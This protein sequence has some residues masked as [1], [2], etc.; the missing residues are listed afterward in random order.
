MVQDCKLN[1]GQ[2]APDYFGKIFLHEFF[3]AALFLQITTRLLVAGHAWIWIL[4][5]LCV[6]V[7]YAVLIWKGIK[8]L[9]P[10]I[11]RARLLWN[12]ILM[13]FAFTSIRY[14]IP[15]LGKNPLDSHLAKIDY[16]IVGK[17]LSIWA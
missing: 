13:N 4:A 11:N 1:T 15:L 6:F 14:I 7:I 8:T 16:W 3:M 5:Y 10:I 9:S 12:I 17:D 2:P